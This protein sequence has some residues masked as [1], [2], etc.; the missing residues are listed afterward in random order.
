[1]Y[2]K[3]TGW[4]LWPYLDTHKKWRP[5]LLGRGVPGVPKA[6]QLGFIGLALNMARGLK[7]ITRLE[8]PT[9]EHVVP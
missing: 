2:A 4:V 5:S 3:L 6:W 7:F 9:A 8:G 1:M